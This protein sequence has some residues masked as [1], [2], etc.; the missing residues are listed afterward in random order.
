MK[1]PIRNVVVEYKNRRARKSGNAL[2]GN[3]DLKSIARE[4]EEDA[5]APISA[6]Q[7]TPAVSPIDNEPAALVHAPTPRI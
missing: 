3:L 2:W 5:K 7:V 1:N 6:D 4:V